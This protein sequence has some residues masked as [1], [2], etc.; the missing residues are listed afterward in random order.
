MTRSDVHC[1][2][3]PFGDAFYYGPERLSQRFEGEEATRTS[4]GF[5][6]VT[7][8]DVLRRLDDASN[9]EKVRALPGLL[10]LP[11]D[12]RIVPTGL[13]SRLLQIKIPLPKCSCLFEVLMA[14]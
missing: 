9:V 5:D 14:L 10:I 4:S 13:I 6:E 7:Y 11:S 8:Q 2:H 12:L 1:V 3:E